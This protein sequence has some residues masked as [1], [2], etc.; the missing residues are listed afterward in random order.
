VQFRVVNLAFLFELSFGCC[1]F[2]SLDFSYSLPSKSRSALR[3]LFLAMLANCMRCICI[4]AHLIYSLLGHLHF[5]KRTMLARCSLFK[6]EETRWR[7]RAMY[8]PAYF[9]FS[10]LFSRGDANLA[11]R[12][13]SLRINQWK[14]AENENLLP[15]SRDRNSIG[16]RGEFRQ[17]L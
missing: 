9:F 4:F 6:H 7:R 11:C 10:W 8:I 14:I 3:D 1:G 15:P 5:G 16:V 17:R 13:I 12:L 2:S